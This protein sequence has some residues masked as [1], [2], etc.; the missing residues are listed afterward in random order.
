MKLQ[1]RCTVDGDTFWVQED[2]ENPGKTLYYKEFG[3]SQALDDCDGMRQISYWTGTYGGNANTVQLKRG[4]ATYVKVAERDAANRIT[5]EYC[6]YYPGNAR[7]DELWI[8][9]EKDRAF[10]KNAYMIKIRWA[11]YRAED[12]CSQYI[13]LKDDKGNKYYFLSD[14]ISALRADSKTPEDCFIFELPEEDSIQ[15]YSVYVE[16][17]LKEKYDIYYE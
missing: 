5:E 16:P 3:V 13:Y 12:I 14:K 10:G 9:M 4:K 15:D 11:E 6:F 7:K 2:R 1:E 17:L 8:K